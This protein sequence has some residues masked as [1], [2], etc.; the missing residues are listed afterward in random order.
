MPDDRRRTAADA[1][2][3]RPATARAAASRRRPGHRRR[4]AAPADRPGRDRHRAPPAPDGLERPRAVRPSSGATR[5][6]AAP[7]G[8]HAV[9]A[10]SP[11]LADQ[12]RRLRLGTALVLALFLVIA[13]RLVQFQLTDAPAYAAQGLE[14]RLQPVDLPAPRGS[15]LDRTGA[16]LAGSVEAR[17]VYA[18]PELVKDPA[19]TADALSPLLGIPR[20][21]LLP[22]LAPH[23]YEDGASVR[24]E[25]LARGDPGRHGPAG[26]STLDLDG[27]GVRRDES[28]VVP[29][30]DLAA[31][32]IGF[33]GRDLTGLG[34][35]EASYDELLRG[36][37]GQRVFEIG[38][39]E[40]DLDLDHE[41]PGG[42]SEETPARPGSS[43]QLTIDRDLQFEV[44]RIL[45]DADGRGQGDHR[46]RRSC[47]T[48]APA[49]SS[50][51]RAIPFYDAANP[52]ASNAGRPG[53][54]RDRP[55][56]GPGLGA[57]GDRVRRLP[58]GGRRH[59]G[60]QRAS[61]RRRSPRATHDVH[62]HPPAQPSRP[63]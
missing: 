31:N 24:F 58:A 43:L 48:C 22:K 50:P 28:R 10:S 35:L 2:R 46:V 3:R 59:A 21:E 20:T 47:S 45:G 40:G 63:R 30:H 13:G 42:Y 23:R 44:Q 8:R 33:T 41:I 15:I 25:Y 14:L 56:A 39:P 32:L 17:Y 18:D 36:V 37:D 52:F 62:R 7:A 51:R 16:V 34:G 26:R 5:G 49:R 1:R 53:R 61:C 60:R 27:I 9:R 6:A 54:H 38:Q 11:P 29:G 19:A 55:G 57:Q 4:G 12:G